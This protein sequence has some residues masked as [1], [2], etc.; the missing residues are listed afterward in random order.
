MCLSVLRCSFGSRQ[1]KCIHLHL[2][3]GV[4]CVTCLEQ[5]RSSPPRSLFYLFLTHFSGCILFSICPESFGETWLGVTVTF[6]KSEQQITLS[7]SCTLNDDIHTGDYSWYS[8][9]Q[10]AQACT[11]CAHAGYFSLCQK[12]CPF[13][14][15]TNGLLDMSLFPHIILSELGKLKSTALLRHHACLL[16]QMRQAVIKEKYNTLMKML[17]NYSLSDVSSR[18]VA[19]DWRVSEVAGVWVCGSEPVVSGQELMD[20]LLCDVWCPCESEEHTF[21]CGALGEMESHILLL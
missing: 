1:I 21:L 9:C 7:I 12:W 11:F 14:D 15:R 8:S 19:R 18:C 10:R 17:Q 6:D 16:V 13:W 2:L 4:N 3:A 20:E 5:H